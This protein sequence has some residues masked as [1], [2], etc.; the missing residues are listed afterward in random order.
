MAII[1]CGTCGNAQSISNWGMKTNVKCESCCQTIKLN[2]HPIISGLLG[3]VISVIMIA[4]V[5][6]TRLD[7]MLVFLIYALASVLVHIIYRR[8]YIWIKYKN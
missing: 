1:Q 5:L 8:F 4:I 2:I 3:L 6:L 7:G